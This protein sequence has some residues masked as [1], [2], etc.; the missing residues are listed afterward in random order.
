MF[1]SKLNS[2]RAARK[3]SIH[4][5]DAMRMMKCDQFHTGRAQGFTLVELLVVIGIIAVLVSILLPSLGRARESALTVTCQ[6]GVR[7]IGLASGFYINAFKGTLPPS[8]YFNQIDVS[9][10]I[11]LFDVLATYLPKTATRQIYTC[12]NAIPGSSEQFPLTYGA[13]G[14][15]H[16]YFNYRPDGSTEPG[17][18]N[19][20]V[21]VARVKRNSEIVS[22][23]D[24]AQSSGVFT[25][26][27]WLSWTEFQFDVLSNPANAGNLVSSLPDWANNSDA[28]GNN[29]HI[30]YRHSKESR[31]SVGFLDGHAESVGKKDLKFRNLNGDY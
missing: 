9:K 20:L 14:R 19:T 1:G 15:V 10:N 6:S 27:G 30:R 28:V 29:Y 18:T 16:T 11:S 31:A 3:Q 12:P 22:F 17:F 2:V 7:Q 8:Y 13:N 24:A 26:G 25:T 23:A 21:R 4:S 5:E